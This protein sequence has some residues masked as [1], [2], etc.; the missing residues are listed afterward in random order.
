MRREV[1]RLNREMKNTSA[2]DEFSK[3]AKL[4]RQHDKMKEQYEERCTSRLYTASAVLRQ[5]ALSVR[6]K[7]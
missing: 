6:E 1:V 4:R 3:W 2:Q 7:G 5:R